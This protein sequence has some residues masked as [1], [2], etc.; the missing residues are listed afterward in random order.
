[1]VTFDKE[2]KQMKI[3]YDG[4][5]VNFTHEVRVLSSM[6]FKMAP[7]IVK[8]AKLA[9]NFMQQAKDLEEVQYATYIQFLVTRLPR[10]DIT[11]SWYFKF[12]DAKKYMYT[13]V[14]CYF[15]QHHRRAHSSLF[16]TSH[17]GGSHWSFN[18][19]SRTQRRHME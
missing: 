7:Q 9:E 15:S 4:R 16:E 11:G 17:A 3:N 6:G 13:S 8:N 10:N 1:M 12:D 19:H 5:L 2:N 18:A 14:D